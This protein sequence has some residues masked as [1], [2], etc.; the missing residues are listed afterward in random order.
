MAD[1]S[2]Y[3]EG[4]VKIIEP[5]WNIKNVINALEICYYIRSQI[6]LAFWSV[7]SLDV[8][9]DRPIDDFINNF[10]LFFHYMK[11]I[12]SLLP[13]VCS[14]IDRRRRQNVVRTSV[15]HSPNGSEPLFLFLPH[16]H[17]VCDL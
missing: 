15:T 9:E 3:K 10:F 7:L 5:T 4:D 12:D 17:V 2:S 11:Q 8:V 6:I 16:F 1:P 13:W 14:V